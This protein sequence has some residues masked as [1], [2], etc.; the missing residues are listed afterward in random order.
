VAEVKPVR[1][2]LSR[3]RGF[4]LQR[5]SMETN[6][7]EAVNVARPGK[8]GNPFDF[9]KSEFCWLALSYGCRADRAGRQAASVLAFEEWITPIDDK[10]LV[11]ME[12]GIS[13]GNDKESIAI[14]PRIEA[15]PPPP[16]AEL[17]ADLAGKNLA[18]WC[19]PGEPCHVDILLRLANPEVVP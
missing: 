19:K 12:R 16:F 1:L 13:F 18:C 14:G 11:K 2:Q 9:R 6:G 3:K 15:G 5:L 8:F 17:V 4:N 7:L 10:K